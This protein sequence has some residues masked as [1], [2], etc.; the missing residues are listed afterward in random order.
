MK[1]LFLLLAFLSIQFTAK[2]EVLWKEYQYFNNSGG[3]NNGV[4]PLQI[5]DSEASDLQNVVFT[6][7][8][9][10]KT[11]D[12]FD[13]I[14]TSSLGSSVDFIGVKYYRQADGTEFLIGV[15]EDD[16]VYKMDYSSG[17]PDG[18]W[19]D[20]TGALSFSAAQDDLAD[21]AIGENT[22]FFTDGLGTNPVI[23][24]SGTGNAA[25]IS[26][27]P[28]AKYVAYHKTMAFAAGDTTNPST[29]YFSDLGDITEWSSGL[30]GN[31][32]IETNDGSIIRGIKVGF[33]ALYIWKD[34]SIWRLSGDN[35]DEFTTQRMVQG[36]GTLCGQS[37]GRIGN[38]FIF[39]SSQGEV[40]VYDGNIRIRKISNKIQGTIDELAFTRFSTAPA[41]VFNDDYYLAVSSSGSGTNDTV[42][43]YDTF[44]LAWTKFD[45]MDANCFTVA[46]NADDEDMLVFGSYDGYAYN[47]PEG[48]NDNGTAI[49]I[50]YTTKQY[51]FEDIKSENKDLKLIKVYANQ[52]ADYDLIV[53]PRSGFGSAGTAYNMNLLGESSIYGTAVYGASTYGGQNLIVKRIEPYLEGEFFQIHYSNSNVDEPIEVKGWKMFV[54]PGEDAG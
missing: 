5:E 41:D 24:W 52:K 10:W 21:F 18:T 8:G 9:N 12:G 2:A 3:L 47:Y 39:L 13:N 38:E 35:K 44:H 26:G 14:N 45:G 31:I 25:A 22:V 48:T 30:S 53:E 16:K 17:D 36:V 32:S 49:S 23:S 4:S 29:L 51:R 43:V 40:Y 34:E 54:E 15:A 46:K 11:R 20:I 33:D 37:I 19:D 7:G 28:D 6:T 42:L 27:A 50:S 1:K